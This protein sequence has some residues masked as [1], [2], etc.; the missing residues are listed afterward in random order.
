MTVSPAAD[1]QHRAA[2]EN[3]LLR[4]G[5]RS[6]TGR[7]I[8]IAPRAGPLPLSSGQR[9]FLLLDELDVA[10]GPSGAAT[11]NFAF[12][13]RMRGDLDVVALRRT[14]T[15]IRRRHEVLR[16]VFVT[17][18]GVPSQQV[19]PA[20]PIPLPVHDLTAEQ[21][22]TGRGHELAATLAAQPFHLA[23]EPPLRCD[24]LRLDEQDHVLL[25]RIHHVA[26]DSWSEAVLHN[27][28]SALYG[29]FRDQAPS[30]LPE[31][32]IQYADYAAWQQG[33]FA[34]GAFDEQLG[35]WLG[36]LADPPAATV[37]PFD[38]LPTRDPGPTQDIDGGA[39]LSLPVDPGTAQR[40]RGLCATHGVSLFQVLL[41]GYAAVLSRRSGQT[42]LVIGAPVANR[43][44][45]ELTGLIGFFVNTIALRVDTDGN[46]VFGE[47]LRRVRDIT[48]D[49][50]GNQETPFEQVVERVGQHREPGR[51]PLV[52]TLLQV[53][54][55]PQAP[56]ELAGLDVEHEQLFTTSSANELS[57]SFVQSADTLVGMWEYRVALFDADTVRGLHEDLFRL[58]EAAMARPES[59]I[60]E[61][62]LLSD[63][64]RVRLRTWSRGPRG[65]AE[66]AGVLELFAAQVD[67]CPDGVAVIVGA[68]QVSYAELDRRATALA[69]LLRARGVRPQELVAILLGRGVEMV[70]S[71]L[72]AFKAGAAYLPLE[73]GYP[74]P[75]IEYLLRD[76]APA[77][78]ITE[79]DCEHLLGAEVPRLL[80]GFDELAAGSAAPV[81][82][83]RAAP[84]ELAYVIYTSGST[85]A[86][87]GVAVHHGGLARYLSWATR[88]YDSSRTGG[89]VLHS[90]LS[91]DLTVTSLFLPLLAGQSIT[92][93]RDE[94]PLPE[95]AALL[96]KPE[97]DLSLAKLTP[98]H[99][100]ALRG[101]LAAGERTDT[102]GVFVIGGEA[103]SADIVST[104]REIAPSARFVNEYGPTEAVV[105]CC[106]HEVTDDQLPGRPVPIGR[107]VD[108]SQLYVLDRNGNQVRPGSVGELWIGGDQVAL[109]YR[110]RPALTARRFRPDP[111]GESPGGR[112]Y[113]T[114]DLVRYQRDGLLELIGRTDQQVKI[115]GYR[116]ELGEV[117][118]ML[119]GCQGVADAVV[120][121]RG[122]PDRAELIG[123]YTGDDPTRPTPAGLSAT[124]AE[125]LPGPL[126]P[127]T[128]V[129]LA[130]LPLTA[131]GKVDRAALPEPDAVAE[132]NSREFTAPTNLV[133]E[134]LTRI[135]AAVLGVHR[136]GVLDDF[137]E[138]GG[139]SLLVATVLDRVA[140]Q[141]PA[142]PAGGLLREMFLRPTVRALATTLVSSMAQQSA[143][144]VPASP[145]A[146]RPAEPAH[147]RG[148]VPLSPA[149]QSLL[150]Q[151][152]L[153]ASPHEY[154]VPI[155]LRL[156]GALD[157]PALR[158]AMA[159]VV[160]RHEILRCRFPDAAAEYCLVRPTGGQPELRYHDIS[161]RPPSERQDAAA[162]LLRAEV[163][164]QLDPAADILLRGLLIRIGTDEHLLCLCTHHL[165]FDGRSQRILLDELTI[166]YAAALAG[167]TAVAEPPTAQYADVVGELAAAPQPADLAYWRETLADT[168][169]LTLPTDRPRAGTR[170]GAGA[171]FTFTLPAE[172]G[173]GLRDTARERS[174]TL[175][176]ILLAGLQ[177]VLHSRSGQRDFAVGTSVAGREP[178]GCADT[179]GP[180]V[181]QVALRADLHGDADL[182]E[183]LDRVRHCCAEAFARQS[184][185]FATVVREVRPPRVSGANPL[186]QVAL[187]LSDAPYQG[188]LAPGL[189]VAE[190]DVPVTVAKY[191]LTFAFHPVGE[192]LV[193]QVEYD[194]ALFDEERVRGM[195]EDLV[196][197]LGGFVTTPTA[198]LGQASRP[199]DEPSG[200]RSAA[201]ESAGPLSDA[202]RLVVEAYRAVLSVQEFG[203]DEDFFGLGGHSMLALRVVSQLRKAFGIALP[204]DLIFQYPTVRTIANEIEVLVLAEIE[205]MSDH[206]VAALLGTDGP[207][208]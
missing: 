72:A 208:A 122:G 183:L 174:A 40:L 126:V 53:D 84:N 15:E 1:R 95:L 117:E 80:L 90:P 93:I 171:A 123:Y 162:A 145:P 119:R 38:R 65:D 62:D 11:G 3:L 176:M 110:G 151:S 114:G 61:L 139:H 107:P 48:L 185:P 82:D 26:A 204:L 194:V 99:L 2:L 29:A 46:P 170:T 163:T 39:V 44:Q 49:A 172:L 14:L 47:L 201:A 96:S 74:A 153:T 24:L 31:P 23:D 181:N 113:G 150:L 156:N 92:V 200:Q 6:G 184:V 89:S 141:W 131:N 202:Q 36:V 106:V 42:D 193:G 57:I 13:L 167:R 166:G 52:Q 132:H 134:E 5:T 189:A 147:R 168:P 133:E 22:P 165:V 105:G 77:L 125:T 28:L 108:G 67:R 103:L 43:N 104:W 124:L 118:T 7:V 195:V 21:D 35:Y 59:R 152:Q 120:V 187:E 56:I 146:P 121:T 12:W 91:F 37:L 129:P 111:F 83:H 66:P 148:P 79:A 190:Q 192:V 71:V 149:Q 186:F 140:R 17:E 154:L 137:F 199:I 73:T 9:R 50:Y 69:D 8:P 177:S 196:D 30:P 179:I 101:D 112:L 198:R 32:S 54:N 143:Q 116:V 81:R 155:A 87:K 128:L 157:V 135:W 98:A 130:R 161:G 58:L 70:V 160:D 19:L 206:E 180:F 136:V 175:F 55:T 159:T 63:S 207:T 115:R 188:E 10:A 45:P 191:D 158:S 203:I 94:Q 88:A 138:L 205:A 144:P 102:I 27:E 68:E 142:L 51:Q 60:A 64:D 33:E 41:A 169:M 164:T 76:A 197:V 178:T 182:N 78:V 75:R 173:S 109:G 25:I 4:R 18:N 97:T 16:T 86:P 20:Q 85:G 100:Q 127:A 34:D